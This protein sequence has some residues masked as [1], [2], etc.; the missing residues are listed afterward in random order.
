MNN[1]F[2]G[3]IYVQNYL[4]AEKRQRFQ[5]SIESTPFTVTM[6]D[7]MQSSGMKKLAE[8]HYSA[9]RNCVVD[10]GGNLEL[11]WRMERTRFAIIVPDGCWDATMAVPLRRLEARDDFLKVISPR[12][13]TYR[14]SKRAAGVQQLRNNNNR[15]KQFYVVDWA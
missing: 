10:F 15:N 7:T 11:M 12:C 5:I 4:N 13:S 14:T 6:L 8:Q 2:H 3:R 9:P 1:R